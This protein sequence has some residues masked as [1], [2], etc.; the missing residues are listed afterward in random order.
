MNRRGRAGHVIDFVGFKIQREGNIVPQK[1]EMGIAQQVVDV[2]LG[3]R[4][5]VVHTQYLM[6]PGKQPLA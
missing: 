5:A 2:L 3:P 1:F 4:K 6:A